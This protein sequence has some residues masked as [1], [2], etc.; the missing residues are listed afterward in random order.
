MV[1]ESLEFEINYGHLDVKVPICEKNTNDMLLEFESFVF[2][3]K[4]ESNL[5]YCEISGHPIEESCQSKNEIC[6][7]EEVKML[8]DKTPHAIIIFEKKGVQS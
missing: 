2:N 5:S 1:L 8:L 3:E 6:G 7:C 4:A